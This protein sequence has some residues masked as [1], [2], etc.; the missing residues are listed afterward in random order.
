MSNLRLRGIHAYDGHIRESDVE[1]RRPLVEAAMAEPLRMKAWMTSEGLC[2]GPALLSTSGTLTFIVAKDIDGI[3]EVTAGTWVFWDAVYN[4]IDGPRFE[5]AGLVASRVVCRPGGNRLTLDAGSKGVS[6]DIPGPP[7][8]IDRPGL[9]LGH[10]SEE[11]QPA[12]WTGQG[13]MPQIGEMVLLAPRH[14]CTT[15][16]L[17]S[18][19]NVVEDGRIVDRWPILCRHGDA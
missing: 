8:V 3:D 13:P 12:E 16:Y 7:D 17:Y 14:I 15:I 1:D 2:E 4:E 11:H 5:Y 6:R 19:F 9:V 18:H 10:A